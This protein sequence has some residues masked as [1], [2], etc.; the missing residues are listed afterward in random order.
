M[1][2]MVLKFCHVLRRLSFSCCNFFTNE[3]SFLVW[4]YMVLV[5]LFPC[6]FCQYTIHTSSKSW[7]LWA[8]G[9]LKSDDLK[10]KVIHVYL[11]WGGGDTNLWSC[12]I[13]EQWHKK[14]K[15]GFGGD[16]VRSL[17]RTH[18]SIMVWYWAQVKKQKRLFRWMERTWTKCDPIRDNITNNPT[19]RNT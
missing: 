11:L 2:V 9:I 13:H 14:I 5:K 12:Y 4:K 19:L 1:A 8:N 15:M 16:Y 18:T 6:S 7:Q 10:Q 17:Q 3:G